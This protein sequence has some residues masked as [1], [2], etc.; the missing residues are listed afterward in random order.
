MINSKEKLTLQEIIDKL[1]V[2]WRSKGC[3]PL[4]PYDMEV[5]AGTFHWSTVLM[6]LGK[7]PWQVVYV[8]PSRRPSDGRFGRHRNRLQHYYQLQAFLKPS[9]K[10]SQ[11]MFLESL[12]CI[13][14]DESHDI[15]FIEDDWES[16]T[17]G[18]W[19]LGWEIWCNGMEIAQYTYFQQVGGIDCKPSSTEFTYGL[20]RIAMYVQNTENI[21]DVVINKNC[22]G[23]S[24]KY[25]DIYKKSEQSYSRFHLRVSNQKH[26]Q[27][28]FNDA[29]EE[30]LRLLDL[31]IKGKDEFSLVR[32]AY[33]Y[34]IKASHLFNSLD[35]TGCL[36]REKR[37]ELVQRVRRM[38]RRCCLQWVENEKLDI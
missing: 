23:K 30:C 8:Q 35:A 5:G 15:R 36:D 26:L 31:P 11:E 37:Q 19:G 3:L 22:F 38:V 2:F 17:L 10:N 33:D 4:Q 27:S 7:N 28:W 14:L 12:S 25:G 32:P 16:P 29:E 9:P 20:E 6:A 18:A 34:C 1:T 24:V 13:G 21:Y